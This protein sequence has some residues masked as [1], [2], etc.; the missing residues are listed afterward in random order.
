MITKQAMLGIGLMVGGAVTVTALLLQPKESPKP[1]ETPISSQSIKSVPVTGDPLTVD[2][3]TEARILEEKQKQRQAMVDEAQART[4]A[5]LAQQEAAKALA[6]QKAKEEAQIEEEVIVN[7]LKVETRPEAIELAEQQKREREQ[8]EREQREQQKREEQ[9]KQQERER[10]EALARQQKATQNDKVKESKEPKDTKTQAEK[11]KV[12]PKPAKADTKAQTQDKKTDVKVQAQDKKAE[13]KKVEAKKAEV[14]KETAQT[15]PEPKTT[16]KTHVVQSGDTLIRLS[17]EYGIPVSAIAEANNMGRHDPLQ[18]GRTIKLPTASE[19]KTLQEKAQKRQQER[20]AQEQ[21]E[22]K[23]RQLDEKLADARKEAKRQGGNESYAVQVALA[24]DQAKAN[25]IAN[26]YKKAG[27]K[28]RTETE[29]RGVRVIVGSER[30]REAATI[31]KDK[32]KNDP[33]VPADGA[34]VVKTK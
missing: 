10:Q 14:K 31:L 3:Q 9:R 15:K 8:R 29:R 23:K 1:V 27:Y 30:S 25:A 2:A 17:K 7:N 16:P 6:L 20:I 11:L 33:S 34:W 28:V 32:L 22:Q 24:T 4:N 26:A 18:R 19:I 5:L 21:A 13:T 12:E